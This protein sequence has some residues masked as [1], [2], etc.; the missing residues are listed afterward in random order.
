MSLFYITNITLDILWGVTC[1]MLKKTRNGVN[2]LVYPKKITYVSEK[3]RLLKLEE[4][5]KT[6][7]KEI[8]ILR[9]EIKIIH[10]YLLKKGLIEC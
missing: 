1:W 9:G 4:D 8:I 3:R 6:Q 10:N 7:E 5:N 2:T